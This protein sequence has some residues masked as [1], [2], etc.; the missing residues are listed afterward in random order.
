MSLTSLGGMIRTVGVGMAMLGAGGFFTGPVLVEQSLRTLVESQSESSPTQYVSLD[1]WSNETPLKVASLSDA[2]TAE[3]AVKTTTML[4]NEDS[5]T[6]HREED[7]ATSE[8]ETDKLPSTAN[9]DR[10]S[11]AGEETQGKLDED[12]DG[13]PPFIFLRQTPK[14]SN[15]LKYIWGFGLFVFLTFL[16]LFVLRTR[17]EHYCAIRLLHQNYVTWKA[18]QIEFTEWLHGEW[19]DWNSKMLTNLQERVEYLE[20]LLAE[21]LKP[22]PPAGEHQDQGQ[23]ASD[24]ECLFQGQSLSD[25]EDQYQGQSLSEDEY[26]Y[27]GQS[28]S[29]DEHQY[30]GQSLSDDEHQY[31]RQSAPNDQQQYQRHSGGHHNGP[32]YVNSSQD[33][34]RRT[35]LHQE[36]QGPMPGPE[37]ELT[38]PDAND[39]DEEPNRQTPPKPVRNNL[40]ADICTRIDNLGDGGV[41]QAH[42]I[43]R[44]ETQNRLQAEIIKALLRKIHLSNGSVFLTE[45]DKI[46]LDK[47]LREIG[48]FN[49]LGEDE[50]IPS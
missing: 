13:F 17:D 8:Q 40:V 19:M 12:Y 24:D 3:S 34:V 43:K 30:Q 9:W 15:V 41:H 21:L 2:I 27:Q 22:D 18:E 45:Q 16:T 35:E 37:E 23:S 47:A 42:E 1:A 25:D 4:S 31:Q 46:D 5:V 29:E 10:S 32:T 36:V 14:S 7:T 6:A 39:I 50:N 38:T 20:N 49:I 28:L 44:L 33:L 26:Q 11:D 48:N